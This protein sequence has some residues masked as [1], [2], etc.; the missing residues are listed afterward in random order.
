MARTFRAVEAGLA[1]P[2]WS[3]PDLLGSGGRPG[4]AELEW[5]RPSG[6][7]RPAWH[8]RAGVARIFWAV[9]AGL[10]QLS[11]SGPSE[12]RWALS[13]LSFRTCRMEPGWVITKALW[14]DEAWLWVPW[15]TFG[16]RF[17]EPLV[18]RERVMGE[19]SSP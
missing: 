19:N 2:S 18:G 13:D 14:E 3:G 7:W 17:P 6:Q 16:Q 8:S 9:E 4:T 10:A 12:A 11:W 1:Q 5:P 15:S